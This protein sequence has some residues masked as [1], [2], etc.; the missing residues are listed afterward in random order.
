[1]T[2]TKVMTITKPQIG[3]QQP[4]T[5]EGTDAAFD[6]A[7]N[8]GGIY[9]AMRSRADEFKADEGQRGN[10]PRTAGAMT[11]DTD[12]LWQGDVGVVL[13]SKEAFKSL[14]TNLKPVANGGSHVQIAVGSGIGARHLVST[15][16]VEVLEREGSSP[17]DGPVVVAEGDWTLTHPEHQDVKFGPGCYGIH[18]QRQYA[19][20]LRRAAD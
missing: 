18:Y 17:L 14:K 3:V 11:P 9:A 13:L 12:V 5:R 19:E 16:E 10:T 1:M 15:A 4:I 8:A 7:Q 6:A 2:K 20:E